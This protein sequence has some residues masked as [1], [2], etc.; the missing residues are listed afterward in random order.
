MHGGRLDEGIELL[1]KP[2]TREALAHKIRHVLRNR[3]QHKVGE[4]K[5]P[6]HGA[7][8]NDEL[9]RSMRSLQILLVEDDPLIRFSTA[10]MLASLGHA[11]TEAADGSQALNQLGKQTFDILM[12]DLALP[13]LAGDELAERAMDIQPGLR[14]VFASGYATLPNAK[15]Q[16]AMVGAVMVQ[17]PYNEQSIAKALNAVLASN[18]EGSAMRA[19]SGAGPSSAEGANSI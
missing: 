10:D 11:V 15:A 17:K 13:G 5:A 3:Q 8:V 16:N 14:V 12:T 2:Y 18:A 7:E 1:S 9:A 19:T 6:H 4:A